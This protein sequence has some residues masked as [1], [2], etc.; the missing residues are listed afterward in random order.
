MDDTSAVGFPSSRER[1][2]GASSDGADC[3]A[4]NRF[5]IGEH[6]NT[7]CLLGKRAAV[8]YPVFC[9]GLRGADWMPVADG[10][11]AMLRAFHLQDALVV[12]KSDD[13]E[14]LLVRDIAKGDL[15]HRDRWS[16][17]FGAI[18]PIKRSAMPSGSEV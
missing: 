12:I 14:G 1:R 16:E 13:W 6:E 9:V 4:I 18:P 10:Q 15:T 7:L 5:S 3:L 8:A 11:S 17:C 2:D